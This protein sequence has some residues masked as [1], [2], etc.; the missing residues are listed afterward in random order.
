M[1]H[2]FASIDGWWIRHPFEAA[3]TS[4]P[5]IS[6][7]GAVVRQAVLSPLR[8]ASTGLLRTTRKRT[9]RD[10]QIMELVGNNPFMLIAYLG[11]SFIHE[12]FWTCGLS[13]LP[14]LLIVCVSV[15]SHGS[16]PPISRSL[17]LFSI[18]FG[19]YSW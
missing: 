6:L 2:L 5:L 13:L 17:V 4:T 11:Y 1:D 3:L 16:F 15:S 18:N 19:A 9:A 8:Y 7:F 12:L 10:L 14:F